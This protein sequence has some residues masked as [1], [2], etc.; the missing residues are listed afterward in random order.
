MYAG[1][2]FGKQA[3]QHGSGTQK[4]TGLDNRKPVAPPQ[5]D[6]KGRCCAGGDCDHRADAGSGPHQAFDPKNPSAPQGAT[7]GNASPGQSV[8]DDSPDSE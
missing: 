4:Q 8:S 5:T 7:S 1:R 2:M 6:R 3:P